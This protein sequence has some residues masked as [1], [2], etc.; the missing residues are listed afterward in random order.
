MAER[1]RSIIW[2]P[3]ALADL[4]GI[5]DYYAQVA[6]RNTAEKIVREISEACTLL[7]GGPVFGRLFRTRTLFSIVSTTTLLKS[8]GFSTVGATSTKYLP[9]T[10]SA[11]GSVVF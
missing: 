5:W 3:E 9:T 7:E 4:E 10:K 6:G 8:S 1:K 11:D 2:S